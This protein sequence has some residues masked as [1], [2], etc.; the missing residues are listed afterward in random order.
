MI[1]PTRT[2]VDASFRDMFAQS[3]AVLA[4]PSTATFER[5]ERRGGTPQAFT[6]VLLAAG[7]SAVIAA[8]FAM[9]HTD[10]TV[11]GQLFTRLISIPVQFAVFTGAVYLIGRTFFQGTG[12]YPEVAYS[13]ALF[14]VPLTIAGTLIGVIPLLGW[15][16]SALISLVMVY[17]GFLAVRSSMNMRD[18]AGAAITLVLAGLAHWVVGGLLLLVLLAPFR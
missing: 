18:A 17:F 12:T 9:F 10:V 7:I 11:L 3:A 14:F 13:F 16:I 5:F 8:F 1:P 15:L 6:Y 4:Q 2:P